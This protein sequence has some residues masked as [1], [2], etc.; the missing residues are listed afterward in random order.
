MKELKILENNESGEK[1][2][3]WTCIAK[4]K[5]MLVRSLSTV[6]NIEHQESQH[7]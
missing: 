5:D 7:D 3:V 1:N 4:G 2:I 6:L